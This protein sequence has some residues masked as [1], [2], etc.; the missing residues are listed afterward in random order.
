MKV[1]SEV[2]YAVSWIEV[3]AE[4]VPYTQVD[5]RLEKWVRKRFCREAEAEVLL[6]MQHKLQWFCKQ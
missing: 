4:E 2:K 6:Q 3:K 5:V 1:V